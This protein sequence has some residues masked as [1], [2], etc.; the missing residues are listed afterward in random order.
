MIFSSFLFFKVSS[1]D[2]DDD[3][4][5]NNNSNNNNNNNSN[6]DVNTGYTT[7]KFQVM[8]NTFLNDALP[9]VSPY[10]IFAVPLR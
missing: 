2:F 5:N 6:S 7:K 9:E 4:D 10:L 3:D 1:Q 8:L